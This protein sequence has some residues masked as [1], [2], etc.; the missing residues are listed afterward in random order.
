MIK[1]K[2][3][4]IGNG[5]LIRLLYYPNARHEI[6]ESIKELSDP[7]YQQ[8]EWTKGPQ[9]RFSTAMPYIIH[10]LYD[11][12]G[13][14]EY[15][16][17]CIQK[18]DV[19][20]YDNEEACLVQDLCYFLMEEIDNDIGDDMGYVDTEYM[21]H[22][23]WPQLVAKAA[24]VYKVMKANNEKYNWSECLHMFYSEPFEDWC[25]RFE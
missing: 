2:D 20:F 10:T 22:P 4:D 16:D 13:D 21:S 12:Y 18:I 5:V 1:D 9:E 11:D 17:V 19:L 23:K 3:I 15:I 24:D 14:L 25:K 7:E 8:R 6:V